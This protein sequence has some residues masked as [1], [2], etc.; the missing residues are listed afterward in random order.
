M[1][2]SRTV[3]IIPYEEKY[4]QYFVQYNL[5]WLNEFF[6]VE[7]HDRE[8]LHNCSSEILEP[9]GFIFFAQQEDEILGTYALMKLS[10][11]EF[12]LTKM[13][14]QKAY[15]GKGIGNTM[16]IHA[17]QF[18]KEQL[19]DKLI[20]YSNRKLE[21]AIHLYRKYGF[22]EIDVEE[23]SPYDRADIKMEYLLN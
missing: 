7:E 9:G 16:M 5:H 13:A 22:Q 12:E 8:V 18:A 6:Y 2:K 17:L 19:M 3:E 21:N 1:K 15:R 10:D 11:S 20:L 14:V 4:K 23:N